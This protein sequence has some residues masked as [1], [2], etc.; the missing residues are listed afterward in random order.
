MAPRIG[1][2]FDAVQPDVVHVHSLLNL[3]F[4]LPR[5]AHARGIPVV[6]TLHDYSLVCPSGGQRVHRAGEHVCRSIETERC[7]DC[8]RESP[9]HAHVASGRLAATTPS[10][11]VMR[12]AAVTFLRRAPRLAR[13]AARSMPTLPVEKGDIDERLAAARRVFEE[14]DLFIAPSAAIA[15]EFER[16]GVDSSRIRVADY[17]FVPLMPGRR[18]G[19]GRPHAPL[20]IG[21]VG[22]LVWHK[23]VHVLIEAVDGLPSAAYELKIFGSP[24]VFPDYSA[25]LRSKAAGL[26]VTFMGAFDRRNVAG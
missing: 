12:R 23:G 6:A 22:T 15:G 4:D 1:Q 2:V 16:L 8:F 17:G 13:Q 21:Y 5:I 14:V 11:G 3:S 10:P 18:N 9:A 26:P 24:D 19:N 7:V 25:D 20:R